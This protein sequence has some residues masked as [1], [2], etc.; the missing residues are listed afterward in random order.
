MSAEENF[1]WVLNSH[2][3]SCRLVE[4]EAGIVG[5]CLCFRFW[6]MHCL[7]ACLYK[8]CKYFLKSAILK[9]KLLQ[10]PLMIDKH[11][12]SLFIVEMIKCT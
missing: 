5:A 1:S 10:T 7:G 4:W 8:S 3:F 11:E 6:K 9:E 2:R 12:P